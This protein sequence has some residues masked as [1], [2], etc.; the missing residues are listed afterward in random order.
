MFEF[1]HGW[2][3]SFFWLP[4]LLLKWP[5]KLSQTEPVF[6]FPHLTSKLSQATTSL[7]QPA[8][9][10]KKTWVFLSLLW[11][12]LLLTAAQPRYLGE[13]VF[14]PTKARELLIAMDLS[15]SMQQ[16]D[17]FINQ[18]PVTRLEAAHSILANFIE[19]RVGDHI[20][21]IVYAD[22]AHLYTPPTPDL[23]AVAELAKEAEIGLVG[24]NT[25]LGDAVA[26]SVKF[27]VERNNPNAVIIL[28]T[29]GMIN[30]GV[31]D[32]R[33][34]LEIAKNS[35]F[36]IYTIG[37]GADEML[38]PG[39]FGTQKI[40]PSQELNE[41][42]LTQLAELSNGQYFRARSV[43]DM[44]QIYQRID[45]LEP[46]ETEA[47]QIRPQKSLAHWPLVLFFIL[48][49]VKSIYILRPQHVRKFLF[50]GE[51]E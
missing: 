10:N 1:A 49:F 25:A 2:I 47:Q 43:H 35:P 19:S 38:V 3:L 27:L 20:G 33:T 48:I 50:R 22:T 28:L 24:K 41:P 4:L 13:P 46:I 32:E 7:E 37:I 29:D 17:M 44:E 45:Q 6:Y 8:K 40:N 18:Q 14:Y 5:R 30:A 42:F 21:L 39:F 26:L 36:K 15:G 16:Q 51:T 31:I 9:S 23:T 34:S 12:C 11:V